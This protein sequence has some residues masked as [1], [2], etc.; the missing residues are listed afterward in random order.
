MTRQSFLFRT[1]RKAS[2]GVRKA[3]QRSQPAVIVRA[4]IGEMWRS[5]HEILVLALVEIS[6]EVIRAF[7]R[8]AIVARTRR[9]YRGARVVPLPTLLIP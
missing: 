5:R 3:V 6:W 1:I 4:V 9:V 8:H 7:V 2:E